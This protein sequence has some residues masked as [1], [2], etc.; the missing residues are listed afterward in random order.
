MYP[1]R[2]LSSVESDSSAAEQQFSQIGALRRR[3]RARLRRL[4]MAAKLDGFLAVLP[5]IVTPRTTE[6]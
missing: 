2:H 3:C 4:A 5:P 6:D 1:G